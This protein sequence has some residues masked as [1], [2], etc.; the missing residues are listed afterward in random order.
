M[1]AQQKNVHGAGTTERQEDWTMTSLLKDLAETGSLSR[2]KKASFK[3]YVERQLDR[4]ESFAYHDIPHQAPPY[5]CE[6][7]GAPEGS[8]WIQICCNQ[9][10][11]MG[12]AHPDAE[13]GDEMTW[14]EG[15]NA[16][17][18]C[19][20]NNG[21]VYCPSLDKVVLLSQAARVVDHW[22]PLFHIS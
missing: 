8:F 10:D 13:E 22:K 20:E 2:R 6:A 11:E 19:L 7:F 21:G 12:V 3:Q 15:I 5:V 18:Y 16:I 1:S 17:L 14:L 9:L 4:L